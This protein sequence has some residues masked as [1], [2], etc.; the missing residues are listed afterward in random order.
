MGTVREKWEA[1]A[2]PRAPLGKNRDLLLPNQMREEENKA[3]GVGY[4]VEEDKLYMMTSI[5][6]SK[7]RKKMR[8][9]QDLIRKDVRE[10]TPDPL[11]RRELLRQVAGIYG[12]IDLCTPTKQGGAIVVIKAFHETGG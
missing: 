6:F 10:K 9:D 11:T 3:L 4:L 2:S 5:N 7:K 8:V 12:P 1:E